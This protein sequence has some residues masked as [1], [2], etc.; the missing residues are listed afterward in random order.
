MQGGGS[1]YQWHPPDVEG[2]S[3]K[4]CAMIFA[5]QDNIPGLMLYR[6]SFSRNELPHTSPS[7]AEVSMSTNKV[8]Q[9]R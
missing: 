4:K 5:Q 3:I 8:Q 1:T 9:L 6:P 2:K 7:T